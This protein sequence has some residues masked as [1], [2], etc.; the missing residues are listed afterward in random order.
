MGGCIGQNDFTFQNN[1]NSGAAVSIN[2]TLRKNTI[3][4]SKKCFWQFLDI[5][6]AIFRRVSYQLIEFRLHTLVFITF[7]PRR[8]KNVL[9]TDKFCPTWCQS[10]LNKSQIWHPCQLQEMCGPDPPENCHLNVKK[11]P[12]TWKKKHFFS[13]I[14]KKRPFL[15]IF[16]LN[17]KFWQVLTF[18]WQFSGGPGADRGFVK[19]SQG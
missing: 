17:V 4:M 5:Q 1:S 19:K 6:M 14:K 2:L 10:Y 8:K 12:K 11:L 7:W 16:F 9:E 3:W 18:K 15:T 13:K